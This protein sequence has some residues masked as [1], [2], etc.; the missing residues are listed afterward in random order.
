VTIIGDGETMIAT[1]SIPR[2]QAVDDDGELETET[3]V[4][5]DGESAGDAE[6]P[7]AAAGGGSDSE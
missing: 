6:A 3:E 7:D 4:V 1:I 5:G 2:M